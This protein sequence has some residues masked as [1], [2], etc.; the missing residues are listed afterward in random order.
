MDMPWKRDWTKQV[1][2][3]DWLFIYRDAILGRALH[4]VKFKWIPAAKHLL[5]QWKRRNDSET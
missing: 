1:N 4:G 5:Q 2:P 3:H